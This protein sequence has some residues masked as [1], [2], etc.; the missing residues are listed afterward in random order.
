MAGPSR[1]GAL[2]GRRRRRVANN[3][4]CQWP[5]RPPFKF[6]FKSDPRPFSQSAG[7]TPPAPDRPSGRPRSSSLPPTVTIIALAGAGLR[8]SSGSPDP[9]QDDG[10]ADLHLTSSAATNLIWRRPPARGPRPEFFGLKTRRPGGSPEVSRNKE[11]LG[12]L[13]RGSPR[14][15]RAIV[16]AARRR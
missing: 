9:A 13:G 6:K 11:T 10:D 12:R 14:P 2:G 3:K 8:L 4:H 1:A 5:T 16:P 7:P 15:A